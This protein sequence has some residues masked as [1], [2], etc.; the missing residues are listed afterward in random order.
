MIKLDKTSVSIVV[1]CTEC[2]FWRGFATDRIDAWIVGVRHQQ[3]IH[4]GDT[5]A[6]SALANARSKAK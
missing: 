3:N 5:Q 4:P 1:L 6:S 2:D